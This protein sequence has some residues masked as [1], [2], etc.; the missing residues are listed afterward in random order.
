[1]VIKKLLDVCSCF[2]VELN[3]TAHHFKTF[4]FL[5]PFFKSFPIFPN[6]SHF[7]R[8][9]FSQV[10]PKFSYLSTI[11][12]I[13]FLN[14]PLYIF[15]HEKNSSLSSPLALRLWCHL[16]WINRGEDPCEGTAFI[17][18]RQRRWTILSSSRLDCFNTEEQIK[19]LV[20]KLNLFQFWFSYC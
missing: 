18:F 14:I 10:C 3:Q 8:S 16:P 9:H 4:T 13:F 11:F 1:M 2:D 12:P 6:F 7:T 19:L 17:Q 15:N 5:K 20:G